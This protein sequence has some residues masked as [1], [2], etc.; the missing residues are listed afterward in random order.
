MNKVN[1]DGTP[2]ALK[3]NITPVGRVAQNVTFVNNNL[4]EVH[5]YDIQS[6]VKVLIALPSLDTGVCQMETK[7]F[8]E[9]LGKRSG[10]KGLV[11]SK[12]LPFASKR[13]C[14]TSNISNIISLS[15]FR[16]GEFGNAFG[17]EMTEG[18]LKGLLARVIFVLNKNNEVVF[19]D[20][21]PDII[22]EPDY[23]AVLTQVDALLL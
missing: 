23:A 13:F 9:E 21:A 10:V 5:L 16:Y 12:D 14:E 3:G 20:V 22:K 7:K 1:L 17:V 6:E 11:I 19:T 15:D 8:N 18:K 4:E 2:V